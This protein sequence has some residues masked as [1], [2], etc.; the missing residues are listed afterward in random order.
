[1]IWGD[2]SVGSG[3]DGCDVAGRGFC[4]GLHFFCEAGG[5]ILSF[6]QSPFLSPPLIRGKNDVVGGYNDVAD[7]NNGGAGAN[8]DADSTLLGKPPDDVLTN[9]FPTPPTVFPSPPVNPPTAPSASPR[10]S[11]PVV[12]PTVLPRPAVVFPRVV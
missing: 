12:S 10:P 8:G 4:D 3:G 9:P 5:L 6:S 1:M 2:G 11:A 7:E